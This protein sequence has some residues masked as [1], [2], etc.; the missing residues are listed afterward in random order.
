MFSF[1]CSVSERAKRVRMGTERAGAPSW[2]FAISALDSPSALTYSPA[3]MFYRFGLAAL[4]AVLVAAPLRGA[5][6]ALAPRE[7]V[8]LLKNG[9]V[10]QGSITKAGDYFVLTLGK[11]GEVRLPVVDV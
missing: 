10:M 7:G 9:H 3:A 5:E 2:P 8:L 4:F 6:P 1:Q 11:T